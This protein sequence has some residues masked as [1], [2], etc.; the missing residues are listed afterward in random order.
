MLHGV[1]HEGLRAAAA[2]GSTGSWCVDRMYTHVRTIIDGLGHAT[3][4]ALCR[5]L[6]L[7]RCR[8]SKIAII[9][10]ERLFR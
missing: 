10:F 6:D 1:N 7:E 2:G 3:W 8:F 9:V 5:F 4:S